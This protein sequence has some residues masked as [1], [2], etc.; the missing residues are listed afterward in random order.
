MIEIVWYYFSIPFSQPGWVRQGRRMEFSTWCEL[1][2]RD[3]IKIKC[4]ILQLLNPLADFLND[5]IVFILITSSLHNPKCNICLSMHRMM[6]LNFLS[7]SAKDG[8]GVHKLWTLEWFID[9]W[10][11]KVV[12]TH[13]HISVCNVKIRCNI[14]LAIIR[15]YI[16][17]VDFQLLFL[18]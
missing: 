10:L 3:S 7:E 12:V 9:W 5:S 18:P 4:S 17:K 15:Y 1:F 14:L 6:S 8:F 16:S 11:R 2:T 13:F